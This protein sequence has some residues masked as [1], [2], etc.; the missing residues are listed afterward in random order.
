M[1]MCGYC[2]GTGR[3]PNEKLRTC[4]VCA[5]KGSMSFRERELIHVGVMRWMY[6]DCLSAE[7][8]RKIGASDA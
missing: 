3:N 1:K 7:D 2:K 5:G 8:K 6:E 4:P